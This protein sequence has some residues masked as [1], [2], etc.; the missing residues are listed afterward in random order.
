MSLKDIL[1]N[2]RMIQN[3]KKRPVAYNIEATGLFKTSR[4]KIN[5]TICTKNARTI[6]GL[7]QY[8][9]ERLLCIIIIR[10]RMIDHSYNQ[11]LYEGV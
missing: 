10:N 5:R 9:F 1:K 4:P 11:N 3:N 8:L 6:C 7:R 2:I